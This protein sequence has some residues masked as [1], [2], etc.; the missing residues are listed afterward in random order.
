MEDC[1]FHWLVHHVDG[2]FEIIGRTHLT[3]DSFFSENMLKCCTL[4]LPSSICSSSFMVVR[5]HRPVNL[6]Y[7]NTLLQ[8]G[9]SVFHTDRWITPLSEELFNLRPR[10]ELLHKRFGFLWYVWSPLRKW[11]E[12]HHL[13][14][15]EPRGPEPS[16]ASA[17]KCS[18]LK[19]PFFF[20]YLIFPCHFFCLVWF[21][22][23]WHWY[24]TYFFWEVS[25]LVLLL[26]RFLQHSSVSKLEI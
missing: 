6:N 18:I 20:L 9:E 5:L 26:Y 24:M 7:S 25:C 3:N 13:P 11:P 12:L 15:P 23:Y 17:C 22:F 16:L 2:K 10:E 21:D 14:Q 19:Y 1:R 8:V 4:K